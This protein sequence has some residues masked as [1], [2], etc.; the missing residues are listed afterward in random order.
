MDSKQLLEAARKL[1]DYEA[2]TAL[3]TAEVKSVTVSVTY[4]QL[5]GQSHLRGKNIVTTRQA[6]L[7][8]SD[9]PLYQPLLD[10]V[11]GS[12]TSQKDDLEAALLAEVPEVAAAVGIKDKKAKP[13]EAVTN[14]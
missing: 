1:Q 6:V 11:A 12:V 8:A 14:G 4:A 10:L 5:G 9:N 3:G 7:V 13:A 2:M